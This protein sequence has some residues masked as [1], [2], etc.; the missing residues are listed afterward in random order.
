LL[1]LKLELSYRVIIS[2]GFSKIIFLQGEIALD[3]KP[4]VTHPLFNKYSLMFNLK[5]CID[6]MKFDSQSTQTWELGYF[7]INLLTAEALKAMK[8]MEIDNLNLDICMN[9]KIMISLKL[10]LCFFIH[11]RQWIITYQYNVFT[12]FGTM[13]LDNLF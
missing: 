7:Y 13:S 1:V 11:H 6:S 5:S 8:I 9:R 4:I 2:W 12:R 3:P 10:T